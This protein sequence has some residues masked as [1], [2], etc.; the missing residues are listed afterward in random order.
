MFYYN[1][2][3]QD[4][5]TIYI[6]DNLNISQLYR[7]VTSY[8]I[9]EQIIN[10]SRATD[11]SPS[12]MGKHKTLPATSKKSTSKEETTGN[13]WIAVACAVHSCGATRRTSNLMT[14]TYSAC[15]RKQVS[16]LSDRNHQAK[17]QDE[18]PIS[19]PHFYAKSGKSWVFTDGF[20]DNCYF[21]RGISFLFLPSDPRRSCFRCLLCSSFPAKGK[22]CEV[23]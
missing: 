16:Q 1:H 9:P 18:P 19:S 5:S 17:L 7:L 8:I 20:A 21:R 3:I 14:R 10:H 13:S 11:S 15:S 23:R 4:D 2:N 12:S 22:A 6:Q